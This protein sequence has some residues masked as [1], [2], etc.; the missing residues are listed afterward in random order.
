MVNFNTTN[1]PSGVYWWCIQIN[2]RSSQKSFS[3]LKKPKV[4][5][6][7]CWTMVSRAFFFFCWGQVFGFG[8]W[9]WVI[10]KIKVQYSLS[11]AFK[12]RMGLYFFF[13]QKCTIW[14]CVKDISSFFLNT[15]KGGGSISSPS[16][17]F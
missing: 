9:V 11:Q 6:K 14:M 5:Y 8:L 16:N 3:A 17:H 4:W 12:S 7:N 13:L 15:S 10:F 2:H 1:S